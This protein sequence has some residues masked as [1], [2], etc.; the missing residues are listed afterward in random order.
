LDEPDDLLVLILTG[1]GDREWL[2]EPDPNITV[3][4]IKWSQIFKDPTVEPEIGFDGHGNHGYSGAASQFHPEGVKLFWVELQPSSAL[5]EDDH[6]NT[7]RQQ[8][9]SLLH[10]FEQVLPGIVAAHHN[11]ISRTHHWPKD[12]VSHQAILHHESDSFMGCYQKGEDH[13]LQ[14]THVVTDKNRRA[15]QVPE[16]LDPVDMKHPP[17]AFQQTKILQRG[18]CPSLIIV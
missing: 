5:G 13:G 9:G 11:W 17:G 15:L 14:R 16:M 18:C 2:S 4:H 6:R 7:F 3:T 1:P 8:A 12:R 10:H